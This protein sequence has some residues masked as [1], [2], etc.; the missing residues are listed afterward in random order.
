MPFIVTVLVLSQV[1]L[2]W[3]TF[4]LRGRKFSRAGRDSEPY[5]FALFPFWS[6]STYKDFLSGYRGRN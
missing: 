3:R 2:G 4:F 6:G 1:T 5:G